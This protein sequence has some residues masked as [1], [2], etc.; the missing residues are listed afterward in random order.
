M[1]KKRPAMAPGA[2]GDATAD[3]AYIAE[4]LR[5]LAVPCD[6]IDVDPRN[7]RKHGEENLSSIRASLR[8]YGQRK[9]IVVNRRTNTVEAGSGSLVAA[10]ELGW[11]HIAAVFVDDDP[12]TAAGFA[13]ADNRTAE[14]AE[15]DQSTL[16]ATLRELVVDDAELKKMLDDMAEDVLVPT[17][18][19]I[20]EDEVPEPP[21]VPVTKP[22]DLWILGQTVTCP[23]CK[24]K[25]DV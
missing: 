12:M 6:S 7:A 20:V 24:R 8:V 4:N 9:P 3:L 21:V 11:T 1:A 19:D 14:L 25:T 18:I 23:R 16:E 5:P 10:R 15:W 2:T 13:I 22:G 17:P